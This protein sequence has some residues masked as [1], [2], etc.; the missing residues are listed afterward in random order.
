MAVALDNAV[1]GERRELCIGILD[2]FQGGRGRTDFGDR[3]TD[4]RRQ[5]A[6]ACDNALRLFIT[7]RDDVDEIGVSQK[8]RI[9]K[10]GQRY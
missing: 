1:P 10:D 5:A 8:R 7:R 2:Q 4:S 9:L 3:R 6:A